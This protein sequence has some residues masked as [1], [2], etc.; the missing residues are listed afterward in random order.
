MLAATGLPPA[1]LARVGFRLYRLG[2]TLHAPSWAVSHLAQMAVDTPAHYLYQI[3]D[4]V[5]S[6]F[7]C[8]DRVGY[9]ANNFD[10]N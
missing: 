5:V 4:D 6:I 3:N 7:I 1:N 8:H 2:D 10:G 9:I